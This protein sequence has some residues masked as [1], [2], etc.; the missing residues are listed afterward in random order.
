[1]DWKNGVVREISTEPGNTA[2]YFTKSG[3]P[4][5]VSPAFFR[6]DVLLRYKSDSDKYTLQDR[7]ISCRGAWHLQTYDIN[8]AGQVHTYIVYLRSL[9]YEE[10]LYWKAHN[11]APKASIS[12]RA[13]RSDFEG[14]WE[15]EYDALQNL[16]EEVRRLNEKAPPWWLPQI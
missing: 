8:E 10:Q 11:E 13:F 14:R 4:F 3:L 2:N 1:M 9:P 7:S 6:P 12:K 15:N 5:E 16:R